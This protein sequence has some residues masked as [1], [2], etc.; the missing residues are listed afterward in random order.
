MEEKKYYVIRE[1]H[2]FK[3]NMKLLKESIEKGEPIILSGILQ[4]ANTL[5]RNG[6]V[7]PYDI[8]RREATKYMQAVEENRALGECVPAGTEIFT[9]EGWKNIEDVTIGEEIFTMNIEKDLL[10]IQEVSDTI[11]KNYNDQMVHIYNSNNLEIL[12]TKKHKIVLWDK[13]DK[14][15][16]LKAEELYEKIKS[17]DSTISHSYIK[18]SAN[19]I[20][21]DI[22]YFTLPNTDL[23]IK[24]E[25]WAAF[26]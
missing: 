15:Y 10:E 4:K 7:Y 20:G 8:L 22:E 14:P 25:D 9:K 5:N 24:A 19:W 13:N 12:V 18:N 11:Q 26:L 17:N 3:P 16:V 21:E 1:F 6:R 23:N 2:E